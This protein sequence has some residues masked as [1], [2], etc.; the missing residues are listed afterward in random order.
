[1]KN[2]MDSQ[3]MKT[4]LL[5]EDNK[6][7]TDVLQK[8]LQV[9]GYQVRCVASGLDVV[10]MLMKEPA[11]SAIILDLMIPGRSGMELIDVIKVKWAT[12]KL[13]I[14][15]AHQNYEHSIPTGLTEGFFLKSE[16]SDRLIQALEI[17]LS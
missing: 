15:S 8:R 5:I 14:F 16:G 11:P 4:I 12:S 9:K 1:M 7:I 2:S 10:E 3:K 17:S 13:F 6:E